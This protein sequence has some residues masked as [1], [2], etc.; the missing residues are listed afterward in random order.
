[1]QCQRNISSSSQ[2]SRKDGFLKLTTMKVPVFAVWSPALSNECENQCLKNCSCTAYAYY[3][4]IGCMLWSGSLIDIQKFSSDGADLYI[5]VAYSELGYIL[6][7]HILVQLKTH[8]FV[9]DLK[10]L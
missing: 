7:V 3:D 6:P 1:M 2:E 9:V 5:R 10:K 8:P 4:G